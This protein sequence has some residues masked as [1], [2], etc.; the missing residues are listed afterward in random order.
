MINNGS[1]YEQSHRAILDAARQIFL[2]RGF[3]GTSTRDI[4]KVA[5]IT[6]PAL[7]SHF[8]DKEVI[9]IAV[10]SEV[11]E[12]IREKISALNASSTQM[13]T[14]AHLEAITNVLTEAHPRDVYTVIHSSFA[15]LK[16]ENQRQLGIIFGRD[17]LAPIEAF[18][19][20][21]AVE[22]RGQLTAKQAAE[23]YMTSLSPLF[24][25]FHR[26]G[27]AEMT[28]EENVR[29]LLDLILHGITTPE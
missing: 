19:A 17:Y 26:L 13:S 20:E 7:Y 29:L 24:G 10:I 9:F 18:F 8:A 22:L 3:N 21:D 16:P 12:M 6:Q 23:F 2:R 27:G 15:Y 1:R 11:G 5:N 14:S 28:Q 4:A 25:S